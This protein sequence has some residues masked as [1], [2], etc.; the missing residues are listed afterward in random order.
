MTTND[1]VEA[2]AN[3]TVEEV[4]AVAITEFAHDGFE[5]TKIEDISRKSGMSKRM[6]HYHFG[7][8]K[9]LYLQSLITAL[10]K[11]QPPSEQ[12]VIDSAVPVEGMRKL[13]DCL[14][15]LSMNNQDSLRM[16][17]EENTHPVLDTAELTEIADVSSVMLHLN[18][19]LMLGQDSGAFRP[20]ISANDLYLLITSMTLLPV[21]THGSTQNLFGVDLYSDENIRGLHRLVVDMVLAFLTSNI[22]DSG[23]QSYLEEDASESKTD[24]PA[25]IYDDGDDEIF[26]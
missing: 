4:I 10:D 21:A 12:M 1:H 13:V 6:I 15:D 25:S 22:P 14:F 2:S 16:L 7:D 5:R 3:V 23:H 8:K 18:R 24:S 26:S 9:G 20:G 17:V 11:L 19:L